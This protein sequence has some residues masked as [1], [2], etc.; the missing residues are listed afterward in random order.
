MGNPAGP[1]GSHHLPYSRPRFRGSG[2]F[3][4]PATLGAPM[5]WRPSDCRP[6]GP[7][8]S[9]RRLREAFLSSFR[10]GGDA[11]PRA[12]VDSPS[13]A[14]PGADERAERI[15]GPERKPDAGPDRAAVL[16]G[17]VLGS[18]P[19]SFESNRADHCVHRGKPGYGRF[20]VPPGTL[21]MVQRGLA[22]VAT[23]ADNG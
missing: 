8:H 11:E 14:D 7:C 18:L 22:G 21:A 6:R 13:G 2:S 20:G 15:D 12:F 17:R 10:L 9:D 4:G 23:G 1:G 16:A 19:S 5:A 3:S